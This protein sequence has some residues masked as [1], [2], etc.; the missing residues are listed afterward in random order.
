MFVHIARLLCE[1]H[2]HV[3]FK[4]LLFKSFSFKLFKVVTF[5][6]RF[7]LLL[8]ALFIGI[9]FALTLVLGLLRRLFGLS[10]AR[11]TSRFQRNA[12][13]SVASNIAPNTAPNAASEVLYNDT[14]VTVLRGEAGASD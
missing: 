14:S 1:S 13:S 6:A 8:I 4:S 10:P 2:S 12:S 7:V 5:M 9:V 11:R 3:S